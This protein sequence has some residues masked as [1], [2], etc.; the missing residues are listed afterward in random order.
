MNYLRT[1]VVGVFSSCSRNAMAAR[2]FVLEDTEIW[3]VSDSDSSAGVSPQAY[4]FVDKY[5]TED[6][7]REYYLRPIKRVNYKIT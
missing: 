6:K 4:E 1:I 5:N 3:H 2:E 7:P